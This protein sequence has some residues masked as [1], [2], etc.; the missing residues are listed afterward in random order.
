MEFIV[1]RQIHDTCAVFD[2][3]SSSVTVNSQLEKSIIGASQSL[4]VHGKDSCIHSTYIEKEE[5]SE[6]R[7][8]RTT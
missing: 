7:L 2:T 3:R 8:K 4:Y 5:A 1:V 6:F